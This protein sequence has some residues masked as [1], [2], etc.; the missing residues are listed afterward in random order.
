MNLES[1][2]RGKVDERMQNLFIVMTTE[3]RIELAIKEGEGF[4]GK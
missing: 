3:D 2:L 4:G 1:E